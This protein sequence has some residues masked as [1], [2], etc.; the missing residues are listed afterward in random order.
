VLDD[1]FLLAATL[2][3]D[4]P[5]AQLVAPQTRREVVCNGAP[6]Q[7]GDTVVNRRN[8]FSMAVV[9]LV[10]ERRQNRATHLDVVVR[11]GPVHGRDISVGRH[12]SRDN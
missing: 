6:R 11:I 5:E 3:V 2:A 4:L 7:A 12:F 1:V 10:F 9:S 8:L